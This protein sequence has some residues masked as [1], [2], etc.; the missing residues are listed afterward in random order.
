LND[1][2]RRNA[3]SEAMLTRLGAA[4]ADAGTNAAVR[5]VVLAAHG[6]AF[7]ASHDLKELTAGRAASD[8]GR[9]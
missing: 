5:V 3:L 9:A 4:F 6:P 1:P 2:R 7:C 8:G